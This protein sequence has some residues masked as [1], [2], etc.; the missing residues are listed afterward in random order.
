M[1]FTLFCINFFYFEY[2]RI[3]AQGIF[4]KKGFLIWN[5]HLVWIL[6]AVCELGR[7]K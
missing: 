3:E 1:S 7:E 4:M 5:P 2:E 6:G